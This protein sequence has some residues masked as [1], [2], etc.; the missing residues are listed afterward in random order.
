MNFIA[1]SG[2]TPLMDLS[3]PANFFGQIGGGASPSFGSINSKLQTVGGNDMSTLM[4]STR[5][6]NSDNNSFAIKIALSST[7]SSPRQQKEQT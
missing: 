2:L 1:S 5:T 7:I 6:S 3:T 4:P